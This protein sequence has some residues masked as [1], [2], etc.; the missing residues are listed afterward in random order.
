MPPQRLRR[1]WAHSRKTKVRRQTCAAVNRAIAQNSPAQNPLRLPQ[2]VA[3]AS[4]ACSTSMMSDISQ[5]RFVTFAR[6]SKGANFPTVPHLDFSP[7]NEPSADSIKLAVKGGRCSFPDR[8]T[9]TITRIS[10]PALLSQRVSVSYL[11]LPAIRPGYAITGNLTHQFD[12]CAVGKFPKLLQSIFDDRLRDSRLMCQARSSGDTLDQPQP[13]HARMPVLADDEVI[14]H[15]NAKRAR[16]V[17]DRL[18]HLDVR[19]RRRRIA[20][21]V[22]VHQEDRGR[23]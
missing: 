19:L 15:R 12:Q 8:Q 16:D 14:V 13:L 10:P 23:G 7:T 2:L 6:Q 3:F 18:C 17:D 4:Q 11:V 21:R 9:A 5:R 22:V 20:G 1:H